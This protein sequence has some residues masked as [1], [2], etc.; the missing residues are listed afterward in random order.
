M[1]RVRPIRVYLEKRGDDSG[2][3]CWLNLTVQHM[4]FVENHIFFSVTISHGIT[5]N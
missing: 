2:G 4:V 3:G 1:Q 5:G